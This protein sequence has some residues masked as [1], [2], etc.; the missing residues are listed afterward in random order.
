MEHGIGKFETMSINR[1]SSRK[2]NKLH[3]VVGL[4]L[5]VVFVSDEWQ[6]Y[7][8]QKDYHWTHGIA[9]RW[10]VVW[11][12]RRVSK[13]FICLSKNIIIFTN[14]LQVE[15]KEWI[16][17]TNELQEM[18][19]TLYLTKLIASNFYKNPNAKKANL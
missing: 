9:I 18:Q 12:K 11:M 3:L 7:G 13:F 10:I 6:K 19:L 17:F 15:W 2:E 4:D 14:S 5:V 16:I 8:S 1:S